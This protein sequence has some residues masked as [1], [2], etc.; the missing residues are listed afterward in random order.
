MRKN[1]LWLVVCLE[2]LCFQAYP[3]SKGKSGWLLI[4]NP[5]VIQEIPRKGI[6]VSTAPV[7]STF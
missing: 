1:R 2:A 6:P 4:E 7:S 3:Q 5:P